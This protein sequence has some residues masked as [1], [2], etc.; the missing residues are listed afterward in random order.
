[1]SIDER[2]IDPIQEMTRIVNDY[3]KINAWNFKESF[4]SKNGKELILNSEWCRVNLV[5]GGWD[6]L[7]GNSISIYYGRLHA[8]NEAA[9]MLWEG[10]DCYAWHDL[11]PALYFL[12]E[13]S[14]VGAVST[15]SSH[16][17]TDKFYE[18][19]FRKTYHRRQPEWL[20]KMHMEV[21]G[22]Y[23]VRLFELFD[24]RR[25]DIWTQYRLFL[26]EYYDIKGRRKS[27]IP[28]LDKVC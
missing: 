13:L 5:W 8:P 14:P 23:G 18:E 7:G 24:L 20:M 22:Y 15:K 16:R 2:N 9:T 11:T 3:S 21:W 25:P 10:E 27:I 12:D 26:K 28:S 17:L 19:E 6:P 4:R 1:M